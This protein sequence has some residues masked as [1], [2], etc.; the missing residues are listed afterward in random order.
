MTMTGILANNPLHRRLARSWK[1]FKPG[2]M[3][4]VTITSGMKPWLRQ[5]MASR[6]FFAPVT[7]KLLERKAPITWR[8][9]SWSSTRRIFRFIS[10]IFLSVNNR[11][12]R[13]A[14][15]SLEFQVGGLN[16]KYALIICP[17][18]L[19][20][21]ERENHSDGGCEQYFGGRCFLYKDS[22]VLTNFN[23]PEMCYDC[24]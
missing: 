23:L 1:P 5:L 8:R 2:I 19:V 22:A 4:S 15:T 11:L 18:R 6:P 24:S 16:Y 20:R 9:L 12:S 17:S 3:A 21:D 13:R 14:C 10:R 7:S